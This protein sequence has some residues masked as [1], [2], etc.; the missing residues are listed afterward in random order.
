MVIPQFY[1]KSIYTGNKKLVLVVKFENIIGEGYK[2]KG[3][4]KFQNY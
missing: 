4:L 2:K 1:P 3:C